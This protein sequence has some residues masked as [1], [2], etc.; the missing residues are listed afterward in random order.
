VDIV[1]VGDCGVDQYL[2]SG[3]LRVGGITANFARHARR[4]FAEDD[5][6]RIAS[7]VGD[8]DS[9]GMVLSSL[10]DSGIDCH[11]SRLPGRTPVQSIEIK[12]DGEKDFVHYDEGV[13]PDWRFTSEQIGLIASSDLLA[14]PVYLQIVGLFDALMNIGTRGLVSVDFADFLEY[15]DFNL[16]ERHLETIDIAF[17]GLTADDNAMI[18]RIREFAA[19]RRKTFIV[20]LG[21]EGSLV[22]VGGDR[23]EWAAVP[24]RNVVDTT[25]AGDAYAAAFLSRYCRGAGIEASMEYGAALAATV[26]TKTG[27]FD[28]GD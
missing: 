27:S 4:E 22:F 3:D 15:P 28:R 7:C 26:I 11:L 16:L 9:A 13:L 20:T 12:P 8:D 18:N 24:V 2:P 17:F 14:A 10:E 1:C 21:G 25:G 5:I 6:V 19:L 23:Y